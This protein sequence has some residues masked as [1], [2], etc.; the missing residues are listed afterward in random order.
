MNLALIV[1]IA[2]LL[3]GKFAASNDL[4]HWQHKFQEINTPV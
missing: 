2:S 3:I 1:N 4:G